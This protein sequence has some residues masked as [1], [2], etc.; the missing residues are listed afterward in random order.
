[1][2]VFGHLLSPEDLRRA[3]LA[4]VNFTHCNKDVID[5]VYL[6]CYAIG[7]LIKMGN[8]EGRHQIAF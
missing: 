2:A 5:A 7:R 4:D 3:S 6:Y 1:M 8:T